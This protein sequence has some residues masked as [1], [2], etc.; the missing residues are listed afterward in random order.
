V[1][2]EPL[3]LWS[4]L[5][6]LAV[7][8]GFS[9]DANLVFAPHLYAES[10]TAEG[11]DVTIAQGFANAEAKA[12]AAGTTFW[13]GEYGWFGDPAQQAGDVSQYAGQEDAHRVGGTWWQWR[14]ACG[15]PHS[16][17]HPGGRPAHVLVHLHRTRCPSGRNLG[18]TQPWATT[19]SRTYPRATPGR[20]VRMATDVASGAARIKGSTDA[21]GT[22]TLVV[23]VPDR[24]TGVPAVSGSVGGDDA[25]ITAGNGGYRVEIPVEGHYDVRITPAT[26]VQLGT[27]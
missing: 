14:Q 4:G 16:I 27:S 5:G 6:D 21:S 3:V 9:H 22:Q 19:L 2:W 23:W 7:P 12:R 13:V 24:H 15:D 26:A 8:T 11:V 1:F 10:I 25:T 20:I 18:L 17:G